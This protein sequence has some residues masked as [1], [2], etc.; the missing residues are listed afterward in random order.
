MVGEAATHLA[1][2]CPS[3]ASL[4]ALARSPT[5]SVWR[6]IRDDPGAVLLILRQSPDHSDPFQSFIPAVVHEPNAL[7]EAV[8][9]LDAPG[10]SFLDWN[11]PAARPI[12][13]ACHTFALLAFQLAERTGR[14]EPDN[15]WTAG[16][17]APLGWLAAAAIDL[18]RAAACLADSELTL[19]PVAVQQK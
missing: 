18:N 11:Q 12:Y 13:H 1:W 3:A 10:P 9:L 14:A 15:A 7:L 19:H 8:R 17:L 5:A 6:E 4:V 16:L 2:L